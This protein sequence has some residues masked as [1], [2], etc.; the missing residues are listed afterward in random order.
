MENLAALQI[1]SGAP[2]E[3]EEACAEWCFECGREATRLYEE[4]LTDLV[5]GINESFCS[6]ACII[7]NRARG[8]EKEAV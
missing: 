5:D 6:H 2:I 1:Y 8:E 3:R 4:P 7:E